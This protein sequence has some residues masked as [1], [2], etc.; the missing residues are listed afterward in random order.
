MEQF[1]TASTQSP[2]QS[3]NGLFLT[4]ETSTGMGTNFRRTNFKD[5]LGG[6]ALFIIS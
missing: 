5:R 3:Q 1:D 2:A 6:Q 4:P